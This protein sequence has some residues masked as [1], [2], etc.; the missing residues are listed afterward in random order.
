MEDIPTKRCYRCGKELP[1]S[2]FYKDKDKK[3]GLNVRCKECEKERVKDWKKNNPLKV[4][5]MQKKYYEANKDKIKESA[6]NWQKDNS[7]RIKRSIKRKFFHL[8]TLIRFNGNANSLLLN[9]EYNNIKS[10][11]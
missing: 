3:D 8:H 7:N 1:L 2:E 10:K 11:I 4:N 5:E 6:I 9:H